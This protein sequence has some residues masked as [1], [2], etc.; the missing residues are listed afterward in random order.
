[1]VTKRIGW[2]LLLVTLLFVLL[3]GTRTANAASNCSLATLNGTYG[4]AIQATVIAQLPGLPAP[5]FPFVESGT[6]TYDGAGDVSVADTLS[7]NGMIAHPTGKGTYTVNSDCT[8]SDE[9]TLSSGAVVHHAGTITG[10]AILQQVNFIYTDAWLVGSGTFRRIVPRVCSLSS[11]S[12]AY[13]ALDQGTIAG[14][15]PL[16]AAITVN[17][18]YDGAGSLSGTFTGSVGGTLEMGTFTGTYTVKPDCTY[19]DNITTSPPGTVHHAGTIT[20]PGIFQEIH[21]IYTDAGFVVP[22]TARK[23]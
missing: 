2:L 17:V 5:P 15:T 3:V 22:G 14:P 11:L 16:P 19:S 21:Y 20:G 4:K 7:L 1:M 18:T 9:I 6:T 23:Q 8:Y 10:R 13:E 12:G